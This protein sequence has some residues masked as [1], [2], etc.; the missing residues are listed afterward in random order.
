[1]NLK[2]IPEIKKCLFCDKDRKMYHW[3]SSIIIYA[4]WYALGI[5]TV[6]PQCRGKYTI[7]EMYAKLS[8]KYGERLTKELQKLQDLDNLMD[9][10]PKEK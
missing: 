5:V 4:K 6:C 3:K 7:A 1:M 9:I 2:N 8:E 10:L